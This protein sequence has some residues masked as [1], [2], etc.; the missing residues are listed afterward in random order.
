VPIHGGFPPRAG[1]PVTVDVGPELGAPA[2]AHAERRHG[3]LT[4]RGER[5]TDST[6]LEA[7]FGDGVVRQALPEYVDGALRLD[8]AGLPLPATAFPLVAAN[9]PPGGGHSAPWVL[10]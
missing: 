8:V 2:I 1:T 4:V 6:W 10:R 3:V 7:D 5:I 9:G